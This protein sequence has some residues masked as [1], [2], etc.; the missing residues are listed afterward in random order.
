MGSKKG[1]FAVLGLSRFGYRV[2]TGL[3]S[4]GA[5]VLAVDRDDRL[6]QKI[7][8]RVTRAARADVLDEEVVEHLGVFDVD[9]AVIGFRSSF[10]AA[11]LV[12]MMLRRRREDIRII[13]QV[14][15]DEKAAALQ[16]VG[17]DVTV[18]PERDIADR[19]VRRLI[20]PDLVEHMDL[21]PDV[22]VVEMAV[23]S[24]FVG[25]SLAEL[26]IRARHQVH[27]IGVIEPDDGVHEKRVLVAPPA[28][29]VF[30]PGELLL[31]LGKIDKIERFTAL[32]Q[33]R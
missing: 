16:Q 32:H 20:T 1:S 19:L 12:T 9:A 3:F 10:D 28:E 21:A 24:E 13:A 31:V 18:F 25:R 6:V 26:G 5:D 27:I 7:A 2:A 17:G 33:S 4:S 15:T 11:V 23:P 14:D 29:T 22:A 8:D 30:R